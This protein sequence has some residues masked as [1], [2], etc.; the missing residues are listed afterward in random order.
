MRGRSAAERHKPLTRPLSTVI[1]LPRLD[2]GINRRTQ[3]KTRR[4]WCGPILGPRLKGEDNGESGVK[5]GL[6][7]MAQFSFLP[8]GRCPDLPIERN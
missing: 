6:Y 5:A 1:L 2:R 4:A 3:R 8:G 7:P